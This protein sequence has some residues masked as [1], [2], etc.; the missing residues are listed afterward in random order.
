MKRVLKWVVLGGLIVI[1]LL[2]LY[3]YGRNRAVHADV[4]EPKWDSP[5]TR[6]L[7]QRVCFDCH[8]NQTHWPWY[9]WV[10]PASWLVQRDVD[11]GREHLDFTQFDRRQRNAGECADQIRSGKMPPWQYKPLHPKSWLSAAEREEL[12]AGLETMFG[13]D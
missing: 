13:G 9:S 5:R 7:A 2:Q 6:E 12:A 1:A 4:A 3:P 11:K 10:A 8:S